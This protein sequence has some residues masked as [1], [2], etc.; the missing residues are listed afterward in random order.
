MWYILGGHSISALDGSS[1]TFTVVYPYTEW[2]VNPTVLYSVTSLAFSN[3]LYYDL[4]LASQSLTSVDV[5][6]LHDNTIT[7]IGFMFM[8]ID[9][10]LYPSTSTE[11]SYNMPGSVS[12]EQTF[13][14]TEI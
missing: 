2:T 9:S 8:F 14:V 12:G 3:G 5:Q 7:Q 1:N 13:A 6:L 11:F 10:T 4:S